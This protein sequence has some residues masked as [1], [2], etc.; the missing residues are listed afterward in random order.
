MDKCYVLKAKV[1]AS[2]RKERSAVWDCREIRVD[3]NSEKTSGFTKREV[4]NICVKL[5]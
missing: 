3:K 2:G 4:L 5:Q 1:R